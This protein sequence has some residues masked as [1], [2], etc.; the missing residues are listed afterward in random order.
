M[1]VVRTIGLRIAAAVLM[2]AAFLVP[3]SIMAADGMCDITALTKILP[4]GMAIGTGAVRWPPNFDHLDPSK[5]VQRVPANADGDGAPEY[6][7]VTGTV[8]TDPTTKRTVHFSAALPTKEHWNGKFMFQGCGGNCGIIV[9]PR[10]SASA[11]KR[12]YPVWST[13]DGHSANP[14]PDPR[15]WQP[16]D[17]AW[18]A[19]APGKRD[20]E[21]IKDFYYRAV[22]TVTEAG[23]VFTK[24]F[25]AADRFKYSYFQGCSDG[26]R[27]AMVELTH[28]PDDYDGIIAGAPYFD[29]KHEIASTLVS[30]VAELRSPTAALS[31]G[32]W[33]LAS[34]LINGICDAADGVKDGLTQNPQAC[35][36]DPYKDLPKC[37]SG[38]KADQCFSPEQIDTLS[39]ILSA[40]LNPAG[41]VIYTGFS[42]SDLGS[43]NGK[44]AQG[45]DILVDWLGFPAPPTHIAGPEPWASNPT[46]QAL[47]WYWAAQTAHYFVYDGA[48]DF[49][50]LK[51]L[52]VSYSRDPDGRMQAV[53]PDNVIALFREKTDAG[54]GVVPE[55]AAKYF[56][57]NK[58]LIMYH[59][60]S[61]GD[62]TPYRTVQY[63]D[64]L[65]KLHGGVSN[66]RKDARLFMAPGMAHCR[67]GA[68]P[69]FFDAVPAL[70][71]WVEEG[72]APTQLIASSGPPSEGAAAPARKMPLCPYPAMARYSG[73]GD[74]N[75]AA[76]WS[77]PADD[78]RL[79]EKGLVGKRAGVY[80]ALK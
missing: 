23:K 70:E 80:E 49:N 35:G 56:Q 75:D 30:L 24:S 36:F 6:C 65:A 50:A 43:Y 44:G 1:N 26:G 72:K 45:G 22:H 38:Q 34:H 79:Y 8:V 14:A 7:Y 59:G 52:G 74:V 54:S 66:L 53:V 46:Q 31:A 2:G 10:V 20:E 37:A 67:G 25:Y 39:I 5:A 33:D 17:A 3:K 55:E 16:A 78:H 76:N 29:I 69:S 63:Y 64:A 51:T 42:A 9:S 32:Q 41:E 47:G 73:S 60:F 61:D 12:G 58:K 13:D 71:Q 48:N 62:I 40:K 77:C 4:P 21:A 19:S 68:G 28:Y 11:L 27:E 15:L 18:A 57:K